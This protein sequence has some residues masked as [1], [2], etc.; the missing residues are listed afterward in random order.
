MEN[1]CNFYFK[2]VFFWA[3]LEKEV[4]SFII[5]RCEVA[6]Q[7]LIKTNPEF[8]KLQEKRLKEEEKLMNKISEKQTKRFFSH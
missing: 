8:T 3:D 1:G 7:E 2:K 6:Y 5:E 4:N